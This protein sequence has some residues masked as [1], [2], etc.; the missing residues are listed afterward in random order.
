MKRNRTHSN[1]AHSVWTR[2]PIIGRLLRELAVW[3]Q[4]RLMPHYQLSPT[5]SDYANLPMYPIQ[6]DPL[7]DMPFGYLD[8]RGIL[9]NAPTHKYP[10]SYQPTS[11]AQFALAHWNHYLTTGLE[12]HRTIFLRHAY[13]LLV[14]E[15]RSDDAG[16]LG[17]W[18][19]PF[20][21]PEYFAEA[22][23]LS[24]LTQGNIISV[25]VRAY[26]LSG[27]P[28]FMASAERAVHTFELDVLDGG[29]SVPVGDDGI[30]FEEVA[31]YPPSHILN[32]FILAL[33][34]L[35]DYVAVTHSAAIDSLI[36]RSLRTLH[37]LLDEYDLGYWSRYDLLHGRPASR[38]YHALHVALLQA[39]ARYSGCSHCIELG[40][41]WAS[42]QRKPI[43]R[44]RY[45]LASRHVRYITGVRHVMQRKLFAA[46][47]A[48]PP[49]AQLP[50]CVPITAFPVAGGMR[51]VLAGVSAVM[52]DEWRFDYLT[53]QIGTDRQDFT[54]HGFGGRI[55]SPWYTLTA[56]IY[57]LAGL[58]KL[59]RLQS[60][61]RY[62]VI[63]PQDG[64]FSGAFAA[65]AAKLTGVR[66]VCMDHGTVTLPYS[67]VYQA[68]R[69][70]RLRAHSLP[71]RLIMRLMLV[72]YWAS[73]RLMTRISTRATDHFLVAGDE[74]LET[75]QTRFRV[76][77]RRI[78]RYPY[79]VD[80]A[81]FK[82]IEASIRTHMRTQL[83]I[84]AYDIVVTMIN[85][86]APE[87][88]MDV[89]M[90]GIASMLATLP[91]AQRA[92]VRVIIAGDG[93]L[94][95][96]VEADRTRYGIERECVLW[97]EAKPDDVVHLL[98]LSDVFLYTGMRGTN[99]S[100]A[101]LEAMAAGCAVV[102]SVEPR[103]NALLLADARGI[104]LPVGDASAVSRALTR[105][106]T[107]PLL[108]QRMG[109]MA[110]EYVAT[111]HSALALKRC[112]LRAT[113]WSPSCPP[114]PMQAGTPSEYAEIAASQ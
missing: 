18:P 15:Q 5:P 55:A 2:M 31:V 62:R 104:P 1:R 91:S 26:K 21:M 79:V 113:Y 72:G 19:I 87:K 33:F 60:R 57:S 100:M 40:S 7:L 63:L 38:F 95:A 46:R 45:W 78:T 107:D 14:H 54:I 61:R 39:L 23:W 35:Y 32:G 66:V 3:R 37:T 89:A 34:G 41:R 16:M 80:L 20:P 24:A 48:S 71:K 83:G 56:W 12:E 43:A 111:H 29:V 17:V 82:P 44:L 4:D 85:R 76:Q 68:E 30:F 75:Y 96:Q 92:S 59:V 9:F 42:Y 51:S 53:R 11:I 58:L 73:L 52:Y 103:S 97:G 22:H 94:R 112:M 36:Q 98:A 8:K 101:I 10:G 105:L 25:F 102:A 47:T 90:S 65:L 86:L 27:D 49:N 13:W 74:V 70:Q 108:C 110:R 93:P 77:P 99:Y 67:L 6:M 69:L 84:G 88:G 81:R 50:I 114:H 109:Q 64:V 28:A 106:V